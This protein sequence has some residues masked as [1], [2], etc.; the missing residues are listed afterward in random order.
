M[1]SS[2]A[3]VSMSSVIEDREEMLSAI[4]LTFDDK[5]S[6]DWLIRIKNKW[7][8]IMDPWGLVWIFE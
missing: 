1:L 7:G 3:G 8:A 5:S 6:D 4:N 2:F